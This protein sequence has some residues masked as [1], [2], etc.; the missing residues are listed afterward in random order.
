MVLSAGAKNQHGQM[1]LAAGT[2]LEEKHVRILKS[3][4]V[5]EVDI[6]DTGDANDAA[7]ASDVPPE[8]QLKA[9]EVEEQRFVIAER[10]HPALSE[11]FTLAKNRTAKRLWR[12]SHAS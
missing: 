5:V 11:L 8:F 9:G 3:W 6:V 1:L 12:E 7:A 2:A 4:G 10:K